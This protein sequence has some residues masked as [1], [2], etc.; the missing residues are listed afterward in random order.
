MPRITLDDVEYNTE[1]LSDHGK[2]TLASLQFLEGQLS[3]IRNEIVIYQTARQSYIATLKA[4]INE[5][6]IEPIPKTDKLS[7]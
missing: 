2:A 4:E 7:D 1:D 3:S 5:S 6:G